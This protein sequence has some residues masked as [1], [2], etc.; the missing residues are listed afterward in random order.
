MRQENRR[1]ATRVKETRGRDELP[2][3]RRDPSVSVRVTRR[4][5]AVGV[6]DLGDKLGRGQA[7]VLSDRGRRGQVRGQKVA[8]RTAA[9]FDSGRGNPIH[10]DAVLRVCGIWSN[11]RIFK[12]LGDSRWP[13]NQG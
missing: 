8:L 3:T 11:A 7:D 13:T 9:A 2:G 5:F 6:A 4:R 12:W 1:D 10:K